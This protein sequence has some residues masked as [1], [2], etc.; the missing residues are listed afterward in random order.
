MTLSGTHPSGPTP[1]PG[2]RGFPGPLEACKKIVVL[3]SDVLTG[4]LAPG[5]P[6]CLWPSCF[7]QD[8]PPLLV[9]T[10]VYIIIVL[11]AVAIV[12]FAG[13]R[14][15]RIPNYQY[16]SRIMDAL[17]VGMYAVVGMQAAKLAGYSRA[18]F[19]RLLKKHNINPQ[20]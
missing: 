17:G 7:I 1:G 9:Q 3:V 2:S 6:D 14:I 18:Q 4:Y 15:L 13:T 12:R 8:G 11:I 16:I 20:R 19:Y 5:R 10:P